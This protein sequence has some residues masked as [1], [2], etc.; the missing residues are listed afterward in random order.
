MRV[1]MAKY[2]TRVLGQPLTYVATV[3]G[4]NVGVASRLAKTCLPNELDGGKD[5]VARNVIM[6]ENGMTEVEHP[7]SRFNR[8]RGAGETH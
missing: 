8:W 5:Q 7:T 3:L 4:C 6:D 2:L 1:L